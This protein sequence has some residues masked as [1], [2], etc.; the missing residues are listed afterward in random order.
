MPSLD[1]LEL[2]VRKALQAFIKKGEFTIALLKEER[3][4]PDDSTQTERYMDQAASKVAS[5][6]VKDAFHVMAEAVRY[7]LALEDELYSLP[8]GVAYLDRPL[9]TPYEEY[10][11]GF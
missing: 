8:T 10:I 2:N 1:E 9:D 7:I 3:D 5:L 11:S 4:Y 6:I